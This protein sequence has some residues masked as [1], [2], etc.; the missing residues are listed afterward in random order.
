MKNNVDFIEYADLYIKDELSKEDKLNFE[1]YCDENPQAAKDYEQHRL[2]FQKLR[3]YQLRKNLKVN[4]ES[5]FAEQHLLKS[6]RIKESPVIE[7]KSLWQK[8]KYTA[9]VAASVALVAVFSTLWMSGFYDNV[10]ESSYQYSLLKRDMNAIKRNVNA[11]NAVIKNINNG[12]DNTGSPNYAYPEGTYGATG[13]A[14]TSNG[15]IATN[16]HVV[17]ESDSVYVQNS[18]GISY[19]AKVIYIDPEYDLAVLEIIDSS[20][21]KTPAVPYTFKEEDTDLGQDV[22]TIGYPREEAVYGSGYLS[23]NTGFGGD[24]VSY[25][26]TIPVN[27]GNSGGPLLDDKG[28]VIGIISGKQTETDGAAFAIKTNYLLQ[29]IKAIP[30]DSLSKSLIIN[31]RNSLAGLSRTN[32]IKKIQD[33]IYIVKVF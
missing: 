31:K 1:K 9:L 3:E 18:K 2:L 21:E 14:L 29:S 6:S 24:T 27:P 25:Q 12:A 5:V 4:M 28:N 33:Y 30:Q 7:M 32:Q 16:Y 17:R 20:F 13:F 23:S 8:Y 22:F 11:Q 10:K 26:V 19:K 15:F